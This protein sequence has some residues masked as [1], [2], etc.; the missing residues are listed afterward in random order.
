MDIK[1]QQAG[2]ALGSFGRHPWEIA[3]VK[4]VKDFLVRFV[5]SPVSVIDIGCG[6]AFV[7]QQLARYLPN[8][9]FYGVDTALDNTLLSAYKARIDNPRVALF[10]STEDLPPEAGKA[11][12]VLL[13]DV[14]EHIPDDSS[15]LSQIARLPQVGNDTVF[16]ITVP[17]FNSL[18]TI[19]DTW[20]GHYRRYTLPMLQKR[21]R[22]NGLEPVYSGYLFFS[23]FLARAVQKA[24][25][26]IKKPD[27]SNMAG[28]GAWKTHPFLDRVIIFF[29]L[30]DVVLARFLRI[31][32][33][34]LPGLS[35]I[36]VCRKQ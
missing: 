1:E 19:H 28:I 29:L 35:C 25:Q 33:I 5:P 9:N 15:F 4:I 14:I 7:I 8:T 6:D 23:L 32:G 17:A 10:P 2:S 31:F 20:L 26:K 11:S 27:L 22:A 21:L 18:F 16:L 30:T 36:S 12:A 24:I 3:R 34:R 13:L